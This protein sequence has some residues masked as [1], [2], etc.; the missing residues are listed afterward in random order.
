MTH[1]VTEVH[2]PTMRDRGFT[3]VDPPGGLGG[4]WRSW[5]VPAATGRGAYHL[6]SP[7]GRWSIAVHD[8]VTDRDEVL[9]LTMP[10]YLSITWYESVAVDQHA[11]LRRLRADHLTGF[12][13]QPGGWRALVHGGVPIRC[14]GVEVTPDFCA[15]FLDREYGGQFAAVRDAFE[16]IHLPGTEFPELRA[17]LAGLRPT[18]GAPR[19]S[20]HYEG[21][22]LQ[23]MGLLVERTRAT[24]AGA[25]RTPDE[26]GRAGRPRG[27]TTTPADAR[28]IRAV[29]VHIDRHHADPLDLAGLSRLARM[30][31]TKFKESFRSVSGT[32][33]TRYVQQARMTRAEQL[34]RDDELSIAQVARAVGYG[35]A[36][37]FSALFRRHTGMLPSEYRRSRR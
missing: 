15:Q 28:R 4:G 9:D 25:G 20:L 13:S 22:V 12:Y 33:P 8:F 26:H 11:P 6:Y 32:T 30:G 37:R 35:C 34:L 19:T 7:T 10:E 23:A 17:L 1:L 31:P 14:V 2:E 27:G 3:P 24:R 29:L 5:A 16:S 18:S 36:S 21:A